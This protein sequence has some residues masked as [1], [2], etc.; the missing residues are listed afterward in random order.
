[1]SNVLVITGGSRG[2][3]K[4]TIEKFLKEGWQAINVSRSACDVSGVINVE[5]DLALVKN[6]NEIAQKLG[7]HLKNAD[8]ICLVHNA[9]WYKRDSIHTLE[10]NDLQKMLHVNVVAA[11]LLNHAALPYMKSGSGIVYIGSTLAEK[12]VPGSASYTITKHAII[13]MMRATTQDLASKNITSCCICPGL[14]DTDMVKE[15]MDDA[16]VATIIKHSVIGG[17]L[18]YPKEIADAIFFCGT[19]PLFNGSVLHANLG[20]QMN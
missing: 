6:A 8:H 18:I 5:L 12:A 16:T 4:A 11:A 15:N 7:S 20:Q 13:G 10:V 9:A 19:N 1:M 17:R 14:V 3:G 2:I